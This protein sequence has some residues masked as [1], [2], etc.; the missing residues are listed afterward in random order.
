MAVSRGQMSTEGAPRKL[1]IGVAS[2][3]IV[4]VNPTKAELEQLTGRTLDKEPEY[5]SSIEVN[6]NQVP[7]VRLDFV[8]KPDPEKYLDSQNQS[9]D[10][11]IHVSLFLRKQYKYGRK[12]GKYQ[13]ID[14][15]GRTAWATKEDIEK[16]VIPVYQTK[17]GG[18][19]QAN[20]SQQYITAY[21]GLEELTK[22]IRA[23][24]NIPTVEKWENGK[25]V[26]LIDNPKEAEVMPEHIEDYF[27][28]DFTELRE[29]FGYQPNNKVK[30]AFGVRTT[31]DN[32]QYQAAY[33]RMFLKNNINDYSKLDKEIASTKANGGLTTTEF[34]CGEFH[35]YAVTATN[36]EQP[37][38]TT[39]PGQIPVMPENEGMFNGGQTPWGQPQF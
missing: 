36:F 28:G 38:G 35:E 23:Y 19:M 24:L 22:L 25:V 2:S 27:K 37:A 16:K 15:Y 20:I 6:G 12:T 30:I 33:T 26:G 39:M 17:D 32:K 11:L 34:E 10:T 18:T 29:I 9:I 4:A 3:Y 8:C 14:N 13:I 21:D 1:Y 5:L 31:D 7:Q